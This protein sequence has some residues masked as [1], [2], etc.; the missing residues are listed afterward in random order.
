MFMCVPDVY[1]CEKSNNG[2]L[3]EIDADWI[4]MCIAFKPSFLNPTPPQ[5][6]GDAGPARPS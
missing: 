1:V 3:R 4:F 6:K 2:C 5:N